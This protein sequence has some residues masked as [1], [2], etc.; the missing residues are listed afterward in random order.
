MFMEDIPDLLDDSNSFTIQ[1]VLDLTNVRSGLDN[2]SLLLN[3]FP[4]LD[5]KAIMQLLPLENGSSDDIL[6][7][8]DIRDT[9]KNYWG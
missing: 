9:L 5:S 6:L 8:N 2:M 1:P 7:L 3:D 4:R